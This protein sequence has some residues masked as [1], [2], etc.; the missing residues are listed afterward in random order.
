MTLPISYLRINSDVQAIEEQ[1]ELQVQETIKEKDVLFDYTTGKFYYDGLEPR[2]IY[3]KV[4]IIKE[5]IKKLFYTERDRWNVH[6]KDV[7][8]PFGLNIYKY[9]G[10]Q[11]YPNTDLIELIKDDIYNSLKNHKDIEEIHCLQ[12]IQIDDKMYCGFIVELKESAFEVEEVIK[13]E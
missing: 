11:L 8:Y 2:K 1:K 9:V 10:Q 13:I 5:W 4:E 3:N 7:G 6:I 12:L